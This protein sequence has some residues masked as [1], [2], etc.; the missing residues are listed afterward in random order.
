M[1]LLMY[2]NLYLMDLWI[3]VCSYSIQTCGTVSFL[4][5]TKP[6]AYCHFI[7]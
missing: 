5:P 3:Q 6:N 2:I 7:L 4:N 1:S